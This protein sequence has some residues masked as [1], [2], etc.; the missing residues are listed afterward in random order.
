M[1][2]GV[3]PLVYRRSML[4]LTTGPTVRLVLRRIGWLSFRCIRASFS[5]SFGSVALQGGSMSTSPALPL[6]SHL[7]MSVEVRAPAE[8]TVKEGVGPFFSVSDVCLEECAVSHIGFA[9]K[10]VSWLSN[11]KWYTGSV[12][13]EESDL[14]WLELFWGFIH[15]T[16]VL[17]PI[18]VW[19]PLGDF[20]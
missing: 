10:L 17:P 2:I 16:L 3:S 14:S 12:D 5:V 9:S 6:C 18:S 11:L 15:D 20:G 8:V 4:G 13:R 1:S 19:W 7:R